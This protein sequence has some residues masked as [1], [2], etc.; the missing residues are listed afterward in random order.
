MSK[1]LHRREEAEEEE[2][3]HIEVVDGEEEDNISQRPLWNASSA[4]T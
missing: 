3:A 4:T 1:Y 2:E